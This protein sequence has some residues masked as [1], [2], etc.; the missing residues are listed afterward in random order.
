MKVSLGPFKRTINE[1]STPRKSN[2]STSNPWLM[3]IQHSI[4]VVWPSNLYQNH[5]LPLRRSERRYVGWAR[6]LWCVVH[7]GNQRRLVA[8]DLYGTERWY[9][10]CPI[11]MS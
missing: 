6:V 1:S 9:M 7:R 3:G 8:M 4:G 2:H 10:T 11:W 5:R